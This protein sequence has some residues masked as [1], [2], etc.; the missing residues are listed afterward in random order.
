[1]AVSYHLAIL[2]RAQEDVSKIFS[3][4][5]DRSPQGAKRWVQEFENVCQRISESPLEFALAP[6]DSLLSRSVRQALFKTPKGRT[7]RAVFI[8]VNETVFLVRVRGPGQP[9]LLTDELQS[10]DKWP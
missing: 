4:I 7:Y 2:P 5:D 6:E 9:P 3:W 10:L 8:V 1:M